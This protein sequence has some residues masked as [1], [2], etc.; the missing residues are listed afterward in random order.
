MLIVTYLDGS[1]VNEKTIQF[2]EG[3]AGAIGV[4]EGDMGNT[5]ADTSR[6]V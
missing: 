5:P 4:V 2:V 3:L 6:S 1:A